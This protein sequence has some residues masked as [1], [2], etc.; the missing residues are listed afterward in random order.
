MTILSLGAGMAYIFFVLLLA[1][2]AGLFVMV[3]LRQR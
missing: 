1:A 3:R 2:L